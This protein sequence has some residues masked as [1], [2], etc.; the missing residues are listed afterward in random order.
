MKITQFAGDIIPLLTF[1]G[2]I[3][4][5]FVTIRQK[6]IMAAKDAAIDTFRDLAD[7]RKAT[8]EDLEY[9]NNVCSAEVQKLKLENA[10]IRE[11]ADMAVDKIIAGFQRAG[12]L[13]NGEQ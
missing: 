1:A 10:A 2:V 13:M 5:V 11:A 8:I 6:G 9:K 3:Y 7:A 4:A 12:Y